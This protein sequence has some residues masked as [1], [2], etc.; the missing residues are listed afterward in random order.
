MAKLWDFL[1]RL[2]RRNHVEGP[3][4]LA[5]PE[6]REMQ[7]LANLHARTHL[8]AECIFRLGSCLC[9]TKVSQTV[10]IHVRPTLLRDERRD[11]DESCDEKLE[12]L[13]AILVAGTRRNDVSPAATSNHTTHRLTNG[14]GFAC[15]G[16][17]VN[18]P[19]WRYHAIR[20]VSCTVTACDGRDSS[21]VRLDRGVPEWCRGTLLR[22]ATFLPSER[23][24]LVCTSTDRDGVG[25]SRFSGP[26]KGRHPEPIRSSLTNR[27][28]FLTRHTESFR[29]GQGWQRL[30]S[31]PRPARVRG[32]GATEPKGGLWGNR[33]RYCVRQKRLPRLG[34]ET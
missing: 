22:R 5:V 25:D 3:D 19:A 33:W 27:C 23:V 17:R 12:R 8:G 32:K 15:G 10:R 24:L 18:E 20:H 7:A 31:P 34:M 2:G 16:Q 14:S 21:K 9:L 6:M 28:R 29:A 1:K 4:R 26:Q 11:R 13:T 30:S